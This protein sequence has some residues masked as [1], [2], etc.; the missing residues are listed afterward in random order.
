VPSALAGE[1][2]LRRDLPPAI[3]QPLVAV[4]CPDDG[5]C[6]HALL[7]QIESLYKIGSEQELDNLVL[8][9]VL[10]S[11]PYKPM[12]VKRVRSSQNSRVIKTDANFSACLGNACIKF[13]D[14]SQLPNL[15]ER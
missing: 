6:K 2:R 14:R 10:I 8:H 4:S 9:L 11:Q 13:L 7:G 15:A 12:G 3:L 1:L 5:F